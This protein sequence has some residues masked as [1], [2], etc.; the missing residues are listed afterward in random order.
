MKN[1]KDWFLWV[2]N[3]M[4]NSLCLKRAVF[5]LMGSQTNRLHAYSSYFPYLRQNVYEPEDGQCE[6]QGAQT[7]LMNKVKA[8]T[9][10]ATAWYEG[11]ITGTNSFCTEYGIHLISPRS[12]PRDLTAAESEK[13]IGVFT[14]YKAT[15]VCI[16]PSRRQ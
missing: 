12:I 14:N 6:K 5:S 10:P 8:M 7:Y 3:E 9:R 11:T 15:N 16:L 2:G 4:I 13:Q 1:K